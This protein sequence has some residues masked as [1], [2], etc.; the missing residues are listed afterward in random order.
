MRVLDILHFP[1]SKCTKFTIAKNIRNIVIN[2]ARVYH[3]FI[4]KSAAYDAMYAEYARGRRGSI[5]SA[6]KGGGKGYCRHAFM[7]DRAR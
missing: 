1:L 6:T 5:K 4:H 3:A 2:L 7:H